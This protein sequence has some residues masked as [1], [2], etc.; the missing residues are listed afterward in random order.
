MASHDAH[1]APVVCWQS[2]RLRVVRLGTQ[3]PQLEVFDEPDGEASTWYV[4]AL[5]WAE[6]PAVSALVQELVYELARGASPVTGSR[7][8]RSSPTQG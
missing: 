3:P 6:A 4:P 8:S 7:P 2:G 1:A 5:P